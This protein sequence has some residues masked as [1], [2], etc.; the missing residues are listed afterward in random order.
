MFSP[1]TPAAC[2]STHTLA[3][4]NL[5]QGLSPKPRLNVPFLRA[6]MITA[7]SFIDISGRLNSKEGMRLKCAAFLVNGRHAKVIAKLVW[8]TNAL[9]VTDVFSLSPIAQGL[10]IRPSVQHWDYVKC[11]KQIFRL[12]IGLSTHD[13]CFFLLLSSRFRMFCGL[14][15]PPFFATS[16]LLS[17]EKC[18]DF[19][20]RVSYSWLN[21]N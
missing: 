17:I 16:I 19:R 12:A 11:S 13:V 6:L 20:L 10:R 9:R 2:L 1:I 5:G 21:P 3:Y 14:S 7:Y 8:G 18:A 15:Q 4:T